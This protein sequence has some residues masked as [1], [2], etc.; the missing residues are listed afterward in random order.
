MSIT[1]GSVPFTESLIAAAP[2]A[3]G[4]FAL[5]QGGGIVYYGQAAEIQRA[6]GEHWRARCVSGQKVSG[7]SWEVAADPQ[8]RQRELLRDY[9]AAHRA[10]PLWNDPQR[11]PTG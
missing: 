11:L 3:A 5:W 6:L 9:A 1:S 7:C 10:L 8:A 2:R 4:V